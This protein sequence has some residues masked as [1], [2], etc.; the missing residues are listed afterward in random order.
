MDMLGRREHS[1]A[2]LQ[3]KLIRKGH[4]EAAAAQAVAQLQQDG[5]VSDERFAEMLLSARRSRGVGPLRIRQEMLE[6]GVAEELVNQWLDVSSRVWIEQIRRVKQ[7]KFGDAL[8]ANYAERA[9]QARFLQY[10]GFT[11]DQIQRVLNA[12]D[13]D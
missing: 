2:E 4:T 5:L 13:A 1:V 10:R 12:D 7:K 8:P 3:E 11:L 9:R 6:K